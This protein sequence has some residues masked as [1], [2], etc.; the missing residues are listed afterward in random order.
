[1][2]TTATRKICCLAF[3]LC[4][5]NPPY[6]T[7]TYILQIHFN[8]LHSRMFWSLNSS[9]RNSVCEVWIVWC[10]V[11]DVCCEV[12][13]IWCVVWGV[14]C[15]VCGVRCVLWGVWYMVCGVWCEM[16]AV[17]CVYVCL[18]PPLP[19][20]HYNSNNGVCNV[21]ALILNALNFCY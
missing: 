13:G 18:R 1:M 6:I 10:V 21:H 9:Q 12:C 14:K 19:P 2:C 8:V 3:V 20:W 16:C 17:R 7:I 11:W 5:R 15:V 4:T